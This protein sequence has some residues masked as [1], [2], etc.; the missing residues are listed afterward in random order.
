MTLNIHR[1]K[2]VE[3]GCFEV[4]ATENTEA[5]RNTKYRNG[6]FAPVYCFNFFIL[7]IYGQIRNVLNRITE[8]TSERGNISLI[9]RLRSGQNESL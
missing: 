8:R 1:E 4:V 5:Q 3:G 6:G 9:L 2:W 7:K